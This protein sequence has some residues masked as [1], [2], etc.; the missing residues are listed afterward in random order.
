MHQP[1]HHIG[2]QRQWEIVGKHLVVTSSSCLHRDGV[3]ADELGRM[4]L[5]GVLLANV[6]FERAVGRPLELS[7]LTGKVRAAHLVR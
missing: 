3:D 2:L 7:Q 5:A 4:G 6:G 1:R